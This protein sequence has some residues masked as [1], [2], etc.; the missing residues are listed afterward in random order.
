MTF[1]GQKV[2]E[3]RET[4]IYPGVTRIYPVVSLYFR[5]PFKK[6]R[7]CTTRTYPV[8][9]PHLSRSKQYEK[10]GF[11]GMVPECKP[12]EFSKLEEGS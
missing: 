10:Y 9:N 6:N 8:E 11:L 3:I 5:G 4:R 1:L 12:C 7:F 2:E